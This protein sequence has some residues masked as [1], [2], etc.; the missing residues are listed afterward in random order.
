MHAKIQT[1]GL[2]IYAALCN[3]HHE[4]TWTPRAGVGNLREPFIVERSINVFISTRHAG[5]PYCYGIA[6]S[7]HNNSTTRKCFRN[8]LHGRNRRDGGNHRFDRD[9]ADSST[10]ETL[11]VM[12]NHKSLLLFLGE[13]G[14]DILFMVH[15]GSKQEI[16]NES[17]EAT[18]L[19]SA[20]FTVMSIL[21][22]DGIQVRLH[23]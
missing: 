10:K 11:D 1:S 15:S 12:H 22:K 19:T 20:P 13:D 5:Q 23:M 14:R 3:L 18:S 9:R 6:L 21:L 4:K 7:I 8:R 17:I 2:G 16:T